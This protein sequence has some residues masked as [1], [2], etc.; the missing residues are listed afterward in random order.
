MNI[1]STEIRL[2]ERRL[3]LTPEE[4]APLLHPSQ[5][6]CCALPS[7]HELP[8]LGTISASV[9]NT[10]AA[11]IVD[12]PLYEHAGQGEK[13]TRLNLLIFARLTR[14]WILAKTMDQ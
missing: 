7:T 9:S 6:I 8:S 13:Y 1:V 10:L 14:A 4:S 3:S 5:D 2:A 11:V 12:A